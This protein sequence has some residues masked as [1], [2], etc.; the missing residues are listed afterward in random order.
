MTWPLSS[1]VKLLFCM[2]KID[3]VLPGFFQFQQFYCCYSIWVLVM[4]PAEHS[5]HLSNHR[6]QAAG[7]AH[8]APPFLSCCTNRSTTC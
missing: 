1:P 6:W 7:K 8:A 2:Q 3:T 5:N 4:P